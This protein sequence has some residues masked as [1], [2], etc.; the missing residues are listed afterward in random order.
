MRISVHDISRCAAVGV[1]LTAAVCVIAQKPATSSQAQRQS[2]ETQ[3]EIQRT[4]SRISDNEK[5]VRQGLSDLQRIEGD[6]ADCQ[7]TIDET[8]AQVRSLGQRINTLSGQIEHSQA[9]LEKLRAEYAKAVR[10]MHRARSR[11][12]TLAFIFSAKSFTQAVRR[13]RYLRE[14]SKWRQK[15][16]DRIA[17]QLAT[18][19]SQ[20]DELR[21]ARQQK[22]K[23]LIAGRNA[24]ETMQQRHGEQKQVVD[25]LKRHGDELKAHLAQKQREADA[26]K[27]Q[28]TAL[29]AQEQAKAK[30]EAERKAKIEA[31]RKAKAE[32]Y[33]KAKAEREKREKEK[34]RQEQGK[35]KQKQQPKQPKAD[36]PKKETPVA[37]ESSGKK[38]DSKDYARARGRKP[39][40]NPNQQSSTA[41]AATTS[42]SGFAA[43]KGKLPRPANGSF[44]IT[45]PFGRHPLPDLPH[46]SYDNPGINAEVSAGA[47]AVAVYAGTVL[48]IRSLPGYNTIVIVSHGDGYYTI[49]GNLAST[50]V[51]KG[52]SVKPGQNIGRLANDPDGGN[53]TMIH[54]EVWHN[55]DKLNPSQWIR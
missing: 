45:S 2:R 43:M 1:L 5:K 35:E 16:S 27:Q 8:E 36:K 40:K 19:H 49:Y 9:Q 28:I 24:R 42:A 44:R 23:A 38:P 26:L 37:G 22:D 48:E 25:E 18:L 30:A 14:F 41:A 46:V 7:K 47:S 10:K 12:S 51:S 15:Q 34:Q 20:Q 13:L 50:A 6:I 54:F 39:R 31:E 11:H 17:E 21:N 53:R 55:Y 52:D 4:K 3:Q 33:R 29:I 32:A